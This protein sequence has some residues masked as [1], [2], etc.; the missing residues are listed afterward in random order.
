MDTSEEFVDVVDAQ[1]KTLFRF[2]KQ[3][4]HQKG[5]LHKTVI[6]EVVNSK[7]EWILV[8]QAASRQDAGKYVSYVGGHVKSGETEEEALKREVFE[9]A[10]IEQFEYALVGRAVFRRAAVVNGIPG[11]E[12]HLFCLYAINTDQEPVPG[13]EGAG[14]KTFTPD[15]LKRALAEEPE[16]FGGSFHFVVKTFYPD[17]LKL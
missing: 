7:R 10:G 15:E 13:D 12:N 16:Q 1:G 3:E 9:E 5:L 17:L 4:A 8:K 14:S 6:G 2:S 11:D